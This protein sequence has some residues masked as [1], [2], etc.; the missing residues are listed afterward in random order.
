MHSSQTTLCVLVYLS[1]DLGL[2]E[3]SGLLPL[4]NAKWLLFVFSPGG[5]AAGVLLREPELA[6]VTINK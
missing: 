2:R 1:L 5:A 3:F 4:P 6:E